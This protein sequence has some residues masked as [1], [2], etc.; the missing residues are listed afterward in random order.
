[1]TRGWFKEGGGGLGGYASP[2][3]NLAELEYIRI[4]YEH[5]LMKELEVSIYRN[6]AVF[7][8]NYAHFYYLH[9]KFNFFFETLGTVYHLFEAEI[10]WKK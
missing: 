5:I 3:P 2:L 9:V 10:K 4:S 6:A 7:E 8:F 1:M